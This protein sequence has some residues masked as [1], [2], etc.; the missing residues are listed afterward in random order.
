LF[1]LAAAAEVDS[2]PAAKVAAAG[3]GV[4]LGIETTSLLLPVLDIQLLWGC[5]EDLKMEATAAQAQ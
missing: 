1:P 3:V 2:E 4:A 5:V